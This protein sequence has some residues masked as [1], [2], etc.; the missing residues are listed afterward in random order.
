MRPLKAARTS[1]DPK[2]LNRQG[3]EDAIMGKAQKP[4]TVPDATD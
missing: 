4:K 2:F 3:A 1:P